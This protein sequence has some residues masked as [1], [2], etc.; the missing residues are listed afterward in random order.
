M[1]ENLKRDE[2][3]PHEEKQAVHVVKYVSF[4]NILQHYV[5]FCTIIYMKYG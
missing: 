5:P 3:F 2:W 1:N 4:Y